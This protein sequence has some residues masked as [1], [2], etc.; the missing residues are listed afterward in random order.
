[1]EH[2]HIV[3]ILLFLII[4]INQLFVRENY[5]NYLYISQPTKC[6]SCEHSLPENKKYMG[7]PTKCFSCEKDLAQRLGEHKANLAQPSKCF[8]VANSSRA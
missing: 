1:M 5:N 8:F 6:L 7:G 3:L 2:L 4:L